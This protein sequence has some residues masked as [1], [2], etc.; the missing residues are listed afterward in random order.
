METFVKPD[1]DWAA[2]SPV[3][4]LLGGAALT[5][6]VPLFL[7]VGVRRGFSAFVAA[8]ALIG[9]G[10][11]AAILFAHD[12][13]GRGIVADALR[14]DRLAETSSSP[15]SSNASSS[16]RRLSGCNDSGRLV[17][18]SRRKSA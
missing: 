15:R 8:A 17:S 6:L 18:R 3:L 12:D 4:V 2:L 1:I 11:A 5:M 10:V 13:S 9:A 14:R 16:F 7:P